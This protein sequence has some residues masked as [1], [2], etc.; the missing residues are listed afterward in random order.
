[1]VKAIRES[2]CGKWMGK[3]PNWECLIRQP[4]DRI[5]LVCVC[6]RYQTGR[7]ETTCGSNLESTHERGLFGGTNIIT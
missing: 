7:N 5:I 4:K 1:M 3:V 2:S 6:G